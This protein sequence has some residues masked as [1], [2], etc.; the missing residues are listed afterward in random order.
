MHD[1]VLQGIS[2][3]LKYWPHP[4]LPSPLLK[5][6]RKFK[7]FPIKIWML[8]LHNAQGFPDYTI[9]FF[10]FKTDECFLFMKRF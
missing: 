6:I 3:T 8:C 2:P 4:F 9:F 1:S 7:S 5:N 10:K